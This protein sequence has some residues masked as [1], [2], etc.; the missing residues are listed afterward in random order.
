MLFYHKCD[1]CLT[2]FASTERKVDLCDCNG[3]VTFMGQVQGN[4]YIKT[5][6]RPPCDGRCTNACGPM[7]DCEC[8]GAN[9][10]TGKLIQVVV[11]EGLVK[12]TGLTEE[13]I[14]RA[15]MYRKFRDYA[16][17]LFDQKFGQMIALSKTGTRMN[18]DDYRAMRNARNKLDKATSLRV[19][20]TRINAL[21]AFVKENSLTTV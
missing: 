11:A 14:E 3:S 15:Q 21:V 2:P 5:E 4:K 9:H 18:Y 1:D 13:D 10:G 8:G 20:T 17:N 12:A 7:C 16:E 6:D 19:H